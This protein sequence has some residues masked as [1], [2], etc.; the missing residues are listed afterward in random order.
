MRTAADI[1]QRALI[2]SGVIAAGETT[3]AAEITDA[4]TTLSDMLDSWSLEHLLVFGTTELT[5]PIAGRARLTI[6][7]TGD[8]IATR[9]NSV[10]TGFVRT[11]QGD[12]PI[13]MAAPEFLDGIRYKTAQYYAYW[14]DGISYK[15]AQDYSYWAAYEGAMP[16]GVLTLWPVPSEGVLHLR[17]THPIVAIADMNDELVLPP[18]WFHAMTLNLAVYLCE[19]YGFAVTETLASTAANAKGAIKRAN[20]RPA[21]ATF[22]QA[23]L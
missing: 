9:P 21:V 19:E 12:T 11:A 18:G 16:D 20:I 14:A 4:V 10:L 17:V 2:R 23:L 7:P 8:L 6:G 13:H 1:A 3:T 22:D 15:T 5:A